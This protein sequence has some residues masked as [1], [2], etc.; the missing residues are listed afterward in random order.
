MPARPITYTLSIII[1]VLLI[2]S[3]LTSTWTNISTVITPGLIFL[4]FGLSA[5]SD[6]I[7]RKYRKAYQQERISLPKS[8][9]N[10]F[11]EIAV[12]LLA[13]LLAA[14]AGHHLT[15][16]VVGNMNVTPAKLITGIGLG[17]IAG[18]AVGLFA[19]YTSS[20]LI[21]TSSGR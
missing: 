7:V 13:M 12:I 8:I 17:L 16:L 4:L 2:L 9:R 14:L 19:K 18:W 21:K 15:R 6:T 10:I 1:A 20:R 3:L 5:T 11:L